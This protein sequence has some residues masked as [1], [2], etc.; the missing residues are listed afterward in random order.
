MSIKVSKKTSKPATLKLVNHIL[1]YIFE[2]ECGEFRGQSKA[3][4]DAFVK[5]LNSIL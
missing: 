1:S 5:Q 4:A 2:E 3:K